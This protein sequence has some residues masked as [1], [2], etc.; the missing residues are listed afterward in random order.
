MRFSVPEFSYRWLTK[1]D[2]QEGGII[3][4]RTI[5]GCPGPPTLNRDATNLPHNLGELFCRFLATKPPEAR[6]PRATVVLSWAIP[7][8]SWLASAASIAFSCI[9]SIDEML[10]RWGS[11]KLRDTPCANSNQLLIGFNSLSKSHLTNSP[12]LFMRF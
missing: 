8:Q 6:T 12:L 3:H 1:R 2:T 10:T 4:I 5:P 9:V 11:P 7:D